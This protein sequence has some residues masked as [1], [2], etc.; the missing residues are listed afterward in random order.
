MV[1]LN[2]INPIVQTIFFSHSERGPLASMLKHLE[3]TGFAFLKTKFIKNRN[4]L[5]LTVYIVIK[6]ENFKCK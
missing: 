4:S 6:R 5:F 1:S 3:Q 2:T